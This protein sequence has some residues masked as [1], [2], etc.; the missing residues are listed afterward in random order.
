[1]P[2]IFNNQHQLWENRVKQRCYLSTQSD[3]AA[4]QRAQCVLLQ[5]ANA[6]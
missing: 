3:F 4:L 5:R 6:R 1:M 2:V